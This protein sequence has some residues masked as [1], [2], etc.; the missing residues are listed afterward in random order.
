MKR[1]AWSWLG[2]F[3]ALACAAFGI[4]A[5][6]VSV[7]DVHAAAPSSV[8]KP[9]LCSA[10]A[11]LP[12]TGLR[13]GMVRIPAG[14]FTMGSQRYYAEEAAPHRV[15]IDAFWI[16]RYDVPNA[17]IARFVKATGYVTRAERGRDAAH[18]PDVPEAMR[19]PG[20][21]VFVPGEGSMPGRWRFVAGADWRHPAGPGSNL[22]GR[23]NHPVVHVAYEDA[24]AYA[25]WVGRELPTEAQWEYAAR[26]GIDGADYV[27]GNEFEPR[28][29]PMANTWQG[30]FPFRN[31]VDDGY[32]G[33]SPVG[34]F[35]ANG[36]GLYDMAGN[37]WQWTSTWYRPG[38]A[39]DAQHDPI[40]PS[41]GESLDPS[42]PGVPARVIKGGSHLCAPNYCMRYRPAARQ[43]REPAFGTSH[44]GFRTVLNE[45]SSK[46]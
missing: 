37:V 12:D 43:P 45:R 17:Q 28:N 3:A 11:G 5:G 42:Q 23:S 41:E 39:Q 7:G 46:E 25:R 10:Y 6:G 13:G 15:E 35:E 36:Y 38:H 1:G 32:P 24:L 2:G 19:A 44:L 9:L 16:D 40:G 22:D 31:A 20:S 30:L 18:Y 21:A 8:K 29:R 33:T 14:D 27:W 34:C 26:G 4:G